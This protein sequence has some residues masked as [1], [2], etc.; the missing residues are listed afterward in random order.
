MKDYKM[1]ITEK[2][3]KYRRY[4]LETLANIN[5]LQAKK[6]YLLINVE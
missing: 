1:I 3:H 4:N 5:I 6:F 2:Q